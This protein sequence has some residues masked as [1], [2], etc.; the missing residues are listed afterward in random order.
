MTGE[1]ITPG[2][3]FVIRPL[4]QTYHILL[5]SAV[6]VHRKTRDILFVVQLAK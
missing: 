5:S 1:G 6:Q 3:A 2:Y 4:S